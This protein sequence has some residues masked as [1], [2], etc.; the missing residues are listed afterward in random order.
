MRTRQATQGG[1]QRDADYRR[2]EIEV[3]RRADMKTYATRQQCHCLHKCFYRAAPSR[4]KRSICHTN[5]V[6]PSVCP[7]VRHVRALWQYGSM[8][9]RVDLY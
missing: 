2:K 1:V 6:R 7:S 8:S 3:A 4:R 5:S 9:D